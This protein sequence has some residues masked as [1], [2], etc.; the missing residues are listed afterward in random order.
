VR[1]VEKALE[2]VERAVAAVN[3]VVIGDVVAIVAE[4]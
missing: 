1:G 2:V 4:R 3:R